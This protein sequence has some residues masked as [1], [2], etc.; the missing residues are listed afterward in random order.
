[1]GRPAV[2]HTVPVPPPVP[3]A[4][5]GRP[6]LPAAC[7]AGA[8]AVLAMFVA[9]AMVDGRILYPGCGFRWLTGLPCPGCGGTHALAA[10]GDGEPLAALACNPLVALLAL[11]MVVLALAAA[12]DHAILGGRLAA[13][14]SDRV[15]RDVRHAGWWML[16]AAV[17]NWIFLLVAVD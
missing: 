2:I 13:F 12:L 1:M 15:R 5:A 9:R 10:L 7:A 11:G 14:V 3:L 4:G 6:R 8:G 16:G 17:V